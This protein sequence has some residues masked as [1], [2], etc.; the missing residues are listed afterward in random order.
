MRKIWDLNVRLSKGTTEKYGWQVTLSG[1]SMET[2]IE[3]LEK[4]NNKMKEK[5]KSRI[6]GESKN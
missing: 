2:I 6:K 4:A 1:D 5:F 3:E